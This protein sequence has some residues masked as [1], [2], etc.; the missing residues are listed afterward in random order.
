VINALAKSNKDKLPTILPLL[1]AHKQLKSRAA[2]VLSVL[3]QLEFL[4]ERFVGFTMSEMP[5]VLRTTLTDLAG[6]EGAAYGELSL[7][8]KQMLDELPVTMLTGITKKKAEILQVQLSIH[9]GISEIRSM[10]GNQSR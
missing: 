10:S 8:V 7:K 5:A 9:D 1:L 6:L 4:P 3:R 2:V